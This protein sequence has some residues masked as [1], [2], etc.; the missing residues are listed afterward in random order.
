[1][2]RP[3]KHTSPRATNA[4][5]TAS[6]SASTRDV[7]ITCGGDIRFSHREYSGDGRTVAVYRC[8]ACGAVTKRAPMLQSDTARDAQARGGKSR[9]HRDIDEGPPL[10]PVIDPETAARL[11]E[12]H[13]ADA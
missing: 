3:V 6:A 12:G 8:R 2:R 7:C 9:R 10:N 11:L 4:H 5:E 13:G 1:M